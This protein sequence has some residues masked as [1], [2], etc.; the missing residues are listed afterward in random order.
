MVEEGLRRMGFRTDSGRG[1]CGGG[2]SG[3]GAASKVHRVHKLTPRQKLRKNKYWAKTL[4]TWGPEDLH[5][6]VAHFVRIRFP[7]VIALNK[8]D[9]ATPLKSKRGGGGSRVNDDG[10]DA[11]DLACV[12]AENVQRIR[13]ALPHEV[14]QCVSASLEWTIV[15]Y[16]RDGDCSVG[17]LLGSEPLPDPA[18]AV[19]RRSIKRGLRVLRP[20]CRGTGVLDCLNRAVA[21]KQPVMVYVFDACRP[22]CVSCVACCM[23]RAMLL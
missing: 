10:N 7:I 18:D 16:D 19:M 9:L 14:V 15:Q 4:E 6:L 11:S 1:G 22:A 17:A 3:A 13:Q 2:G 5:E 8:I 12:V 20:F 21:S 23:T